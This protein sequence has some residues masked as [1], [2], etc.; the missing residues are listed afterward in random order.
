M[1]TYTELARA[2]GALSRCEQ[3]G[4]KEWATKWQATIDDIVDSLPHGSGFDNGT[5]LDDSST[6]EKLIFNTAFH[7][8]NDNGMY[9]GWSE[10]QVI[11][12]PSLEMGY[13]LKVTGRNR[14]DIKEYIHECFSSVLCESIPEFKEE[15]KAV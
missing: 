14:N 5:K 1:K 8:M 15:A 2:L 4:N 6:P 13:S 10:H 9:D 7:H 11:L 12:T 3:S